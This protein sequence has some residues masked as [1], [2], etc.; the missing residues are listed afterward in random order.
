MSYHIPIR[1]KMPRDG[2]DHSIASSLKIIHGADDQSGEHLLDTPTQTLPAF[3]D[4]LPG[5]TFH[6]IRIHAGHN[7]PE[8]GS[9]PGA[10]PPA[11]RAPPI[12]P[13]QAPGL[14]RS[15]ATPVRTSSVTPMV[16]RKPPVGTAQSIANG[17]AFTKHVQTQREFPEISSVGDFATL[18]ETIINSPAEHKVLS[19]GREAFWDGKDTVVIYN[20]KAGDKGTCFRPTAGKRYF[21]NLA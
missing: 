5:H 16:Q 19:N 13:V 1:R 18:I 14:A 17:H 2:S 4:R 12:T 6:Q 21:D 20:P 3:N 15:L 9:A 7:A 8:S 10:A 11:F